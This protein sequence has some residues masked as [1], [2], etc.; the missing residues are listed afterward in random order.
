MKKSVSK[1]L[2]NPFF[3]A[4]FIMAADILLL[5]AAAVLRALRGSFTTAY[6]YAEGAGITE[7]CGADTA[8]MIAAVTALAVTAA[9]AGFIFAGAALWGGEDGSAALRV[10]TGAVMLCLSAAAAGFAV[11]AVRGEQPAESEYSGFIDGR[12]RVVII[13]EEE[14]REGNMLKVYRLDG[15]Q[16]NAYRLTALSLKE[17][18]QDSDFDSRYHL[19]WL[20]DGLLT[21]DFTD[22]G[23]YRTLTI[24]AQIP[25]EDAQT[26]EAS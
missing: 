14:Y 13:V 23:A 25:E 20:S 3:P 2:K 21:L 22:G 18:T 7:S 16:E 15:E 9:L 10:I 17:R 11:Y 8:I 24:P 1:R 26:M 12:G 19:S 6:T 4:A 5:A